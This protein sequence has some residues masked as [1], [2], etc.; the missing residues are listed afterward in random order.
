MK[1][2]SSSEN[3]SDSNDIDILKQKEID[4]LKLDRSTRKLADIKVTI[5]GKNRQDSSDERTLSNI[6]ARRVTLKDFNMV[7]L[8][9][10]GSF[11][12]VLFI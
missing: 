7:K 12:K 6:A 8:V 2:S 9:G 4:K 3:V 11:G 1:S 10:K 5:K